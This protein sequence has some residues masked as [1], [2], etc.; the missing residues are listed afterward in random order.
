MMKI[1]RRNSRTSLLRLGRWN[2]AKVV[3]KRMKGMKKRIAGRVRLQ[4]CLRA[5]I[6]RTQ[7]G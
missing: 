5:A 3:G 7:R 1:K 4:G 6:R 2:K